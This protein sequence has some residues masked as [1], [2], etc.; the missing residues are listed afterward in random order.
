[1]SM[2]GEPQFTSVEV[3]RRIK[4]VRARGLRELQVYV[5]CSIHVRVGDT[6]WEESTLERVNH[7]PVVRRLLREGLLEADGDF[8]LLRTSPMRQLLIA[9]AGAQGPAS[10][11]S[12]DRP[13][14]S[15]DWIHN[16]N[17]AAKR[18]RKARKH[19]S[20]PYY[21]D[22]LRALTKGCE[23]CPA[24]HTPILRGCRLQGVLI[25]ADRQFCDAA[26]KMAF[27][28]RRQGARFGPNET[29]REDR[30]PRS[31]VEPRTTD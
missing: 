9:L 11:A 10:D 29:V 1:V 28:R 27:R 2:A 21:G 14:S 26:C 13:V 3:Q 20:S 5:R 17:W 18:V 25:A 19:A 16:V 23:L 6:T 24:C 15:P 4:A 22:V 8:V 30:E 7:R 12:S 31:W